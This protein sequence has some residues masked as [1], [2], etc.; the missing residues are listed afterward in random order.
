MYPKPK[1]KRCRSASCHR[2]TLLF[3]RCW[4]HDNLSEATHRNID[5]CFSGVSTTLMSNAP[6][7]RGLTTT[8]KMSLRGFPI[9]LFLGAENGRR[10]LAGGNGQDL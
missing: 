8:G 10:S 2:A 4:F 7:C 9:I 1:G 3:G 5:K 6:D